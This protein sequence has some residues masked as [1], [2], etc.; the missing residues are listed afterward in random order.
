MWLTI[1]L[2]LS[3]ILLLSILFV[4][5]LL[6]QWQQINKAEERWRDESP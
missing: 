3:S 6:R 5:G 1:L 4:L 2:I